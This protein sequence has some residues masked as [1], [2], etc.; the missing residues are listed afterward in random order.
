MVVKDQNK[1][2]DVRQLLPDIHD[3]AQVWQQKLREP[4]SRVEIAMI[5]L[6][7]CRPKTTQ[8][9]GNL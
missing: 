3:S 1:V 2:S 8:T 9:T 4:G 5:A 7:L 6:T